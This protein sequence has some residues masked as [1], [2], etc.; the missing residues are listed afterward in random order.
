[1]RPNLG[2]PDVPER[3][4][5]PGFLRFVFVLVLLVLFFPGHAAPGALPQGQSQSRQDQWYLIK[6]GGSTVG[7]LHEALRSL[8]AALSPARQE[9]L[10]TSSDMRVVL[11]RLGSKIELSFNST[12]EESADGRLRSVRSEMMASHQTT[13]S[14]A[15]VKTDSIELTSATGGKSYTRTLDFTGDLYGPEGIRQL[16]VPR[17]KKPGDRIT[18]QTFVAEVSLVSQLTRTVISAETLRQGQVDIPTLK[19]EETLAGIPVKRTVWL[20]VSGFVVK[21]EEPGPF[22]V[23][24]AVRSDK[25]TAIAAASGGELPQEMY[26]KSIVRTN[27]R[28]PRAT[29]I[30]RMKLRLVHHSPGLG[31]PDLNAPNQTAAATDENTL[32]LEIRR[33]RAPR[34]VKFPV[35]LTEQNR[36]FL[37][38]NVYIQSDDASIQRLAKGL[39]SR[40]KDAFQAALILERWVAENMKFD[41][42]IVFA[43]ATEVFRDRRGTC[44]GYATLL[45]TLTR[46]VGI[47]SRVVM[48]YVY[49]LGMFGG[50]AWTE[51]QAGDRWV[52]LDAAIVNA[53]PADAS[54][55]YFAASSLADGLGSLALG[56]AQ[57][58]FGQVSIE[59]LEY[60]TAGKAHP[61]PPGAKPFTVEG[62]RYEN[63]WLGIEVEKPAGFQFTRLDSVWPDATVL[64][65]AGPGSIKV[66]LEQREIYPWQ[67]PETGVWELLAGRMPEGFKERALM[68]GRNVFI[69]DSPSGE[70]AAAA[71]RRGLEVFVW[72]AE[73]ADAPQMVRE[74][75][76]AF[77]FENP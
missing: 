73:G 57:Q 33:P 70:R 42:G 30:D 21:Q 26:Q 64:E 62:N 31:W 6:I 34:G 17:L 29:G 63:R 8:P 19:V 20:D 67:E 54:R 59:I 14:E 36:P 74:A 24:E 22:G 3:A 44:V 1:M 2:A 23:T 69:V 58:V 61:V 48:G 25:A 66:T 60:E 5:F 55:F 77:E 75:A 39:V 16:S 37:M 40:E 13:K 72:T 45:A 76:S 68:N 35:A 49:A 51:I 52:P 7:Y 10:Q 71:F 43:P 4:T 41:L 38:P 46:A 56:P 50:H 9:V 53:G 32:I 12:S 11:N 28:L 18:V 15:V 27:I 65:L 47:P